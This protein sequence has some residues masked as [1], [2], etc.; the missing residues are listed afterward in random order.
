M[1]LIQV[2]YIGIINKVYLLIEYDSIDC[3]TLLSVKKLEDVFHHDQGQHIDKNTDWSKSQSFPEFQSWNIF[4][5]P[6]DNQLEI[7]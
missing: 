6:N 5:C 1:E 4:L 7:A 3:T 2:G